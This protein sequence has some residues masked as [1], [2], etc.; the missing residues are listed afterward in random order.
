MFI[1]TVSVPSPKARRRSWCL[2]SFYDVGDFPVSRG[3]GSR[4]SATQE[5][6]GPTMGRSFLDN[7]KYVA[8]NRSLVSLLSITLPCNETARKLLS[9]SVIGSESESPWQVRS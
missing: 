7:R 8:E 6:R 5:A 2:I 9:G 4:V 1:P 3:E